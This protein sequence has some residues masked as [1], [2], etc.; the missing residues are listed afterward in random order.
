MLQRAAQCRE[1]AK[2]PKRE[3]RFLAKH[4]KLAKK[5]YKNSLFK[6]FV[7]CKRRAWFLL[8]PAKDDRNFHPGQTK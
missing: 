2:D 8:L 4:A 1:E 7:S 3:D 5:S 6:N